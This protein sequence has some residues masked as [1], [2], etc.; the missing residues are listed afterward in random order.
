MISIPLISLII[1]FILVLV[2]IQ[3][4]DKKARDE[5]DNFLKKHLS[6]E[7]ERKKKGTGALKTKRNKRASRGP[8]FPKSKKY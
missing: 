7:L 2:I 4:M 1:I 8:R 5:L 3:S 6:E